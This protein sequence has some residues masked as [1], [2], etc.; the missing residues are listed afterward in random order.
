[1]NHANVETKAITAV[2][3]RA[4]ILNAKKW[5]QT[6]DVN[7]LARINTPALGPRHTPVNHGVALDLFRNILRDS[8][9][10][11]VNENGM[12]S[13]DDMKYVYTADVTDA[14]IQDFVFT[15]GFVNYNN[16]QKS[17]TGLAGERV[18][19]CSNEMF[20]S[21]IRD[22]YRKHTASIVTEL[23]T[24]M[25]NI[26]EYFKRFRDARI[27][28]IEILK[29][30]PWGDVELGQFVV[31]IHRDGYLGNTNIGRIIEEYDH[32]TH[33]EFQPKTAWNFQNACT[34]VY[35]RIEDPVRRLNTNR[36]T[37]G[38][39]DT[40]LKQAI[41]VPSIVSASGAEVV[42]N[43]IIDIDAEEVD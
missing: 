41:P 6:V 28:E 7:S 26:V 30:T 17:F 19:I 1:M 40:I 13:R 42:I 38:I 12:L 2:E 20:S 27:S 9:L 14:Q 10:P 5:I 34:E 11:I 43:D 18:F 8:N 15:I 31:A 39:M 22:A 36:T 37:R 21:Q 35:K 16:C 25:G 23:R 24:K 33:V 4:R 32:P 29:T 3:G